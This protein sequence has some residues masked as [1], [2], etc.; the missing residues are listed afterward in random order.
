MRRR[1]HDPVGQPAFAAAI[2]G[3]NRMRYRRR[4][5]VAA[6][7]VHHRL[8]AIGSQ[9]F[10]RTGECRHRERVRVHPEVERTADILALAI[11]ANRLADREDVRLVERRIECGPAMPR[12]AERDALRGIVRVGLEAVVGGDQSR[13]VEEL[14]LIDRFSGEWAYIHQVNPASISSCE[15]RACLRDARPRT[16]DAHRA[17]P[18]SS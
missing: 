5:R 14:R 6:R 13:H 9:H 10:E 11:E 3:Q 7:A 16:C 1:D 4:R 15:S 17:R 2:V 18:R 12:R 8:D